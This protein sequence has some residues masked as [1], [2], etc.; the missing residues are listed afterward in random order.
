MAATKKASTA[1]ADI[2]LLQ[3]QLRTKLTL[4]ELGYFL[5]NDSQKIAPYQIGVFYRHFRGHKKIEAISGLPMPVKEAPS[6]I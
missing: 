4:I 1:V 3:Q 5:V 2:L 6:Y